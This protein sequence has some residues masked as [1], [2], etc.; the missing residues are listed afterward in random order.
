[1]NDRSSFFKFS[2]RELKNWANESFDI[3]ASKA[4]EYCVKKE[5]A[6]WYAS[7][8]KVHDPDERK[9]V[10]I[11]DNAYMKKQLPTIKQQLKWAGVRLG[12]LL[13]Q[14]LGE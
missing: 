4:V 13:N 3:T 6:C 7:D 12:Y 8:N 1:M 2:N 9:R 5:G 10:M 14:V 11:V